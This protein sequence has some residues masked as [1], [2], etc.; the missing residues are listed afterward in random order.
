[1][2]RILTLSY[3]IRQSPEIPGRTGLEFA[4]KK[5]LEANNSLPAH[6]HAE[7]GTHR[8]QRVIGRMVGVAFVLAGLVPGS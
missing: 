3:A 1:L 2:T 4:T 8:K 5:V 7:V 6:T